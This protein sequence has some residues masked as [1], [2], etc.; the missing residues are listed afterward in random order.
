MV[1]VAFGA[2]CRKSGQLEP[3]ELAVRGVMMHTA[4]CGKATAVW[5]GNPT[6]RDA[7][8]K[9]PVNAPV[10]PDWLGVTWLEF[11]FEGGRVARY[12]TSEYTEGLD[13]SYDVFSP[14]CALVA[15][16][17]G[18]FGPYQVMKVSEIEEVLGGRMKPIEVSGDAADG[19]AGGVHSD[20]KWVS[21][22]ELEFFRGCCGSTQ[23]FRWNVKTRKLTEVYFAAYTP[24]G[25]RRTATGFEVIE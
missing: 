12:T 19:G 4:T 24:S 22:D 2:G 8:R 21:N 11:H 13:W 23:V 18:R 10:V 7:L 17:S 16:L 5:Y 25:I 1:C 3:V 15:L 20:A 6:D 14:D 9:K